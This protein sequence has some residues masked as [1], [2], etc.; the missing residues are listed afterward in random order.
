M[1]FVDMVSVLASWRRH[2]QITGVCASASGL[3]PIYAISSDSC[4]VRLIF[5]TLNA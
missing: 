2:K 3:S 5:G 1:R 4:S